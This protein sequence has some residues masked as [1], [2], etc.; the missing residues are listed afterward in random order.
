MTQEQTPPMTAQSER[1]AIVVWLRETAADIRHFTPDDAAEAAV[2]DHTADC[3]ERGD[4]H[5]NKD[6]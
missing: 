3:I 1:A 6:I 2:V 4:H 5:L